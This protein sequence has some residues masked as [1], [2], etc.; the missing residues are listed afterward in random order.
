VLDELE[1][2]LILAG[3]SMEKVLKVNVYL[4]HL[5]NYTKM[6]PSRL[7]RLEIHR[8]AMLAAPPWRTTCSGS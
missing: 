7:R 3:S 1:Q 5:A 8:T 6:K 4:S 2:N